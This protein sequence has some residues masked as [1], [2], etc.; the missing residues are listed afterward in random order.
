MKIIP[1]PYIIMLSVFAGF[2]A[3]AFITQ[4]AHE[5][6]AGFMRILASRSVLLTDYIAVGGVGA[7]LL[8]SAVVGTLAVLLLMF[9]GV[10]P[11]GA[12]VMAIWLTAGFAFLA[13]TSLI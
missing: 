2:A 13:K 1:K 6:F 7:T 8:N 4:P 5:I 3:F 11:D 9:S 12:I 10:K